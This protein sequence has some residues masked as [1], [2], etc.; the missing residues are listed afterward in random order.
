MAPG[1]IQID[2]RAIFSYLVPGMFEAWAGEC[3]PR[4][5]ALVLVRIL[6]F[7]KG[8]YSSSTVSK[9]AVQDNSRRTCYTFTDAPLFAIDGNT[10]VL[11]AYQTQK[12]DF[13]L[14]AV[15]LRVHIA[16]AGCNAVGRIGSGS[17]CMR[18]VPALNMPSMFVEHLQQEFYSLHFYVSVDLPT[19]ETGTD[20][21][22]ASLA[23]LVGW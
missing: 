16:V 22:K 23:K 17:L 4:C 15:L 2:T 9:T 11:Q 12:V 6:I 19:L 7:S 5:G 1:K 18:P 8:S 21:A 20:S 10:S 3:R 13:A 14:K